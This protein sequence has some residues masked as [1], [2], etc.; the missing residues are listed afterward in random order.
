MQTRPSQC[1]STS[2]QRHDTPQRRGTPAPPPAPCHP[3]LLPPSRSCPPAVDALQN[4]AALAVLYLE[5]ALPADCPLVTF[6]PAGE[7]AQVGKGGREG[8]GLLASKPVHA[9]HG[10]SRLRRRGR[11]RGLAGFDFEQ[12]VFSAIDQAAGVAKSQG[13]PCQ[14]ACVC[15][16]DRLRMARHLQVVPTARRLLCPAQCHP[17]ALLPCGPTARRCRSRS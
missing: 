4:S 2:P 5:G 16:V 17:T 12:H 8:M 6:A 1:R 13:T 7:M 14:Q 3:W 11:W 15:P 10:S 9:Q